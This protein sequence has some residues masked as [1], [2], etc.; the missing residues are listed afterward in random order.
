MDQSQ[1]TGRRIGDKCLLHSRAYER[2]TKTPKRIAKR[3]AELESEG[4]Q[5]HHFSHAPLC[6]LPRFAV[7][8]ARDC[9]N[10][11]YVCFACPQHGVRT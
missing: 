8:P 9:C 6:M 2:I 10:S 3:K 5:V 7:A 1:D 11:H 4:Y